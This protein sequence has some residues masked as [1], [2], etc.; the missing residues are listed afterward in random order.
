[1]SVSKH[2]S[3]PRIKQ[4]GGLF[5]SI[6]LSLS[7]S[8]CSDGG[9]QE[10]QGYT[11]NV[12]DEAKRNKRIEPLPT[13]EAYETYVYQSKGQRD[14]F[15]AS[16]KEE[17]NQQQAVENGL[18]PDKN[19]RKEALESYPLDSLR[20]VGTLEQNS[21]VSAVIK[22][23][24]GTIHRIKTGNYMGQ[25]HGRIIRISSDKVELVEII[26]NG[27]GNGWRER[28]SAVALSEE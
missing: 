22:A 16:V 20:M 9:M 12:K 13:F 26:P 10:L 25:N 15:T 14:P 17:E 23:N 27:L 1:M 6:L 28:E 2:M 19:R 21:V 8:G 3:L 5:T 4:L 7:V 11:N 24:D 18:Q